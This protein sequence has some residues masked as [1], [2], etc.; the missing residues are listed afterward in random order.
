MSFAADPSPAPAP[1]GS[2]PAA[3]DIGPVGAGADELDLPDAAG[4][5]PLPQAGTGRLGVV[6]GLQAEA[7][8]VRLFPDGSAVRRSVG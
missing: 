8:C 5:R 3:I 2:W 4:M 7:D 6:T 1:E